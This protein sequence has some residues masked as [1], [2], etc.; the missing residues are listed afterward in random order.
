MPPALLWL[1]VLAAPAPAPPTAPDLTSPAAC[2]RCHPA[3]VAQWQASTHAA[4]S[5]DNPWYAGAFKAFAA[6]RPSELAFCGQCHDPALVAAGTLAPDAT[7]PAAR[8]GIGCAVCHS[9]THA[10]VTGN[11]AYTLST[12]PIPVRG[13]AHSARVMP[14]GLTGATRCAPCHEVRLT[15]AVTQ[16]HWQRGQSDWFD[17][18]DGPWAGRGVN[19]VLRPEDGVRACVDCH[20]PKVAAPRRERGRDA[21]GQVRDHRFLGSH[22]A[23][24]T[25]RGDTATAAA[26][27]S[28]L[29]TALA[30]DLATLRPGVLDVVLRNV[31]VGHAFPGGTQDAKQAWVALTAWDAEGQI[32]SARG[33]VQADGRLA[34]DTWLLRAR[35]VDGDGRPVAARAA[36]TQRGVVADT[37]LKPGVPQVARFNLPPTAARVQ[38]AVRLR[39]VG[40]DDAAALCGPD[41]P[42][43]CRAVPIT[44]VIT[45]EATLTEGQIPGTR[46]W[47]A[48]VAHGLGLAAGL[49]EH[50]AEAGALL[51]AA[52]A[53][54]PTAV[55][56]QL[57]LAK[58]AA[59]QGRT[60][61]VVARLSGIDDP[62]ARW[63]EANA[64]ARAFR[65]GPAHGAAE[66]LV[67]AAP[68]DRGALALVA[69]LRGLTGDHAGALAAA[70]A[71]VAIDPH[72]EA[73]LYQR[74]LALRAL[75]RPEADAA[76]VAWARHRRRDE[77]D[78]TLRDAYRQHRPGDRAVDGLVGPD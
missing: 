46:P 18:Y 47:R 78:R 68:D 51:R 29:R 8:A 65:H 41:A 70:D 73:G 30:I 71:L 26:A 77:L 37:R 67:A 39:R 42:P 63:I 52:A 15:E 13:P 48:L 20:M 19:V 58:H 14:P 69:R 43:A 50:V 76:R 10:P 25:L 17:W 35:P 60:D 12:T 6:A 28:H 61:D 53:G 33:Q 5:L 11:A 75:G 72:C 2:Q 40:P 44:D 4:S 38:V 27:A 64:L 49:P 31:G 45:A 22:V 1:W 74:L 54:A 16:A 55:E 57:A 7:G 66:R 3:V 59:V 21:N 36:W 34:P 23:L 32:V 62:R 9:L 24:P 56:P